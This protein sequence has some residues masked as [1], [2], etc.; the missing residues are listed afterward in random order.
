MGSEA[1]LS[2]NRA[3]NIR[4][5]GENFMERMEQSLVQIFLHRLKFFC[6]DRR[7]EREKK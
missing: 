2:K 7:K 6:C 1:E 5:Q 4:I 3:Q